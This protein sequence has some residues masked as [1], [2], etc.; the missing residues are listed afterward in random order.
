M[1]VNYNDVC[2]DW[3]CNSNYRTTF[4]KIGRDCTEYLPKNL[5]K[6]EDGWSLVASSDLGPKFKDQRI[7]QV[8]ENNNINKD[9]RCD[10]HIERYKNKIPKHYLDLSEKLEPINHR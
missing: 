4:S 2:Q 8:D 5:R 9:V 7:G 10:T 3:T 6:V 1:R